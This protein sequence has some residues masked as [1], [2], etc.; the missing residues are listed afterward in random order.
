[1]LAGPPFSHAS[2]LMRRSVLERGGLWYD[3]AYRTAQ[4]YDL[5]LRL[6]S[7]ARGWNL[8]EVLLQHRL[9]AAQLSLTKSVE[10]ARNADEIR[11]HVLATIDIAASDHDLDRH[12]KLFRHLLEPTRDNADWA[13]EWLTTIATRNH[14]CGFFDCQ[15]L[16]ALLNGVLDIFRHSCR[17]AG[18][19]VPGRLYRLV[20]SLC[21]RRH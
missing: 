11:R 10:Q 15:S 5:W 1:L 3:E 14:A 12:T 6:L 9:H 16:D 4:D 20:G 21:S 18:A 19:A 8:D 7:I 17:Q 13:E 2:V